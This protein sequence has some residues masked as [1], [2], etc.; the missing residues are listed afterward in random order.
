M[1]VT[2]DRT[3]CMAS[4]NCVLTVPE[5]FEQDEDGFARLKP[6]DPAGFSAAAIEEAVKSCPTAAISFEPTKDAA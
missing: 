6:V 1:K 5:L 3:R 4:G 2:I